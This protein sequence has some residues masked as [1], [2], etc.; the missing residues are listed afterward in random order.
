MSTVPAGLLALAIACAVAGAGLWAG[1]RSALRAFAASVL[2]N[3][4][5]MFVAAGAT[6]VLALRG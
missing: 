1:A 4:A 5:F 6:L 3:A 2:V